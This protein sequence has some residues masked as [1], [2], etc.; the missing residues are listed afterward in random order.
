[1]LTNP[2]TKEV[3]FVL[4]IVDVTQ[5]W[6]TS[7]NVNAFEF[8]IELLPELWKTIFGLFL[9]EKKENLTFFFFAEILG[10]DDSPP[11]TWLP[12]DIVQTQASMI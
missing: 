1:M 5:K 10:R 9:K 2:K 4:L 12:A 7:E 8:Q 11:P 6:S 3:C